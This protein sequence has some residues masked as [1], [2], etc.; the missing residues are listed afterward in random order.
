[1][2]AP[3]DNGLTPL[4]NLIHHLPQMRQACRDYLSTQLNYLKRG[5]PR[6]PQKYGK[7]WETARA[8]HINEIQHL[9]LTHVAEQVAAMLQHY[10]KL[11]D[12]FNALPPDPEYTRERE[13]LTNAM[14]K[15][16]SGIYQMTRDPA[17]PKPHTLQT[18]T[19]S[20]KSIAENTTP[21]KS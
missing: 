12:A 7:L 10:N 8:E 17:S 11:L 19:I 4:R 1:M 15:T 6:F 14:T 5:Q 20:P 21:K 3:E 2:D 18:S 9:P 16:M 13:R